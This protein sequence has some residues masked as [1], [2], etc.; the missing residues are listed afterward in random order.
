MRGG[1]VGVGEES[2]EFRAEGDVG[3][4]D[5]KERDVQGGGEGADVG[6]EEGGGEG[7]EVWMGGGVG[8]LIGGG[9]KGMGDT[10]QQIRCRLRR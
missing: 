8:M 2:G 5:V 1:E 10:D 9:G 3:R 7:V 6:V 4:G